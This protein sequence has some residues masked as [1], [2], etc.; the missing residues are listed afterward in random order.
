MSTPRDVSAE[1]P[2]SARDGAP[3]PA[4]GREQ[5]HAQFGDID[6]YLF[7]Q[8]LRGRITPEMRILDAGCGDGRNA[9]YLLRIGADVFGVDKDAGQIERIQELAGR[10]APDLPRTNFSVGR[11]EE[12]SFP[13]GHFGAVICN[14][15]L[16]FAEDE[17]AFE[18]MVADIWRVLAPGGVFFARLASTIGIEDRV[19]S[20]RGRWH[21]IPDGTER[22]LVD[23]DYLLRITARL[24][25]EL[26]DPIKT[27]N[28]Q[29]VRAMTTWVVGKDAPGST[30]WEPRLKG[31]D[32]AGRPP[33]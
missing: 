23:E 27:T 33:K 8:L 12:L 26:L 11:L 29:N 28:V 32:Y 30:P 4:R 13:D 2:E 10:L 31:S 18:R 7:D 21:K 25:G 17:G 14:A 16:H 22:F 9:Y 3:P 19:Q 20:L 5:L 15:V 1:T 24:G 6:I